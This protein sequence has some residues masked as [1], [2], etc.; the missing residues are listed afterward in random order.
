MKKTTKHTFSGMTSKLAIIE[1]VTIGDLLEPIKDIRTNRDKNTDN[2]KARS[3]SIKAIGIK[4][5][6][7]VSR[8]PNGKLRIFD[9]WSRVLDGIEFFGKNYRCQAAIYDNMSEEE[10]VKMNA[11]LN[12]AL[13][14]NLDDTEIRDAVRTMYN[15]GTTK[16]S[17][18][19]NL[20]GHED[21]VR[22]IIKTIKFE[23]KHDVKMSVSDH[24]NAIAG[25]ELLP[26]SF[27]VKKVVTNDMLELTETIL[28]ARAYN[29]E[30]AK[31]NTL[32]LEIMLRDT[33]R[34]FFAHVNKATAKILPL[35]DHGLIKATEIVDYAKK[36][37]KDGSTPIM[38]TNSEYKYRSF[39]V[40]LWYNQF[41]RI[42][43][44]NPDFPQMYSPKFDKVYNSM[45]TIA[46]KYARGAKVIFVDRDYDRLEMY[47]GKGVEFIR[48]RSK[49]KEWD[50][51]EKYLQTRFAN[52]GGKTLLVNHLSGNKD[53][54]ELIHPLVLESYKRI[55]PN[56]TLVNIIID[57]FSNPTSKE[58]NRREL[59]RTFGIYGAAHVHNIKTYLNALTTSVGA[60]YNILWSKSRG[61]ARRVVLAEIIL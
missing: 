8:L 61:V 19:C 34:D 14:E 52:F 25:L 56:L 1:E 51:I 55:C 60:T 50:T 30:K 54:R 46:I 3:K 13:R 47:R 49:V 53:A 2:A 26:T 33:R 4:A 21:W 12:G 57:E 28:D 31:G 27:Y 32:N 48:P 40:Y 20:V 23:D 11:L 43:F 37:V 58:S 45:A 16:I 24:Q 15:Q 42:I 44:L 18:L 29:R 38:P 17:D 59:M 7:S 10:E 36:L 9:G 41:S 5:L 6:L 39:K 35:C 22:Q